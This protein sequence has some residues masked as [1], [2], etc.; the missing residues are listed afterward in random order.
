MV[1]IIRPE[2]KSTH[3][4]REQSHHKPKDDS[5]IIP[6]SSHFSMI[7]LSSSCFLGFA[8]LCLFVLFVSFCFLRQGF[9]VALKPVLELALVDQA[10]L[11]LRDLPSSVS[12][13]ME[14]KVCATM[15]CSLFCFVESWHLSL[16]DL[17]L[18][19]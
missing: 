5:M 18:S 6:S 15:R 8:F 9:S 13:V 14:L 3:T 19:L 11:R 16:A 7:I 1:V 12:Q 10:G 4:Q 17:K 2:R